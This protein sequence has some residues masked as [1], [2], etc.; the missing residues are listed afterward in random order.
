[1]PD[2]IPVS[3]R[4]SRTPWAR[5]SGASQPETP[6]TRAEEETRLYGHIGNGEMTP[7]QHTPT[8]SIAPPPL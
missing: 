7:N 4:N 3:F 5:A 6:E 8:L 2:Q 1:M